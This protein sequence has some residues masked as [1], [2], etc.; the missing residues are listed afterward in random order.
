M[1]FADRVDAGRRLAPAVQKVA[2]GDVVVLGLPRGGV[3]VAA[4]VAKVLGAPLDV[5]VVRKLGVPRQPELAMGAVGEGG[6]CVLEPATIRAA[7]VSQEELAEIQQREREQVE[8]RTRMFRGDR[9]G[10]SLQGRT[11]IVVDDGIAT[12]ATM[13]AAC[14]IVRERGARRVVAAVPVAAG[15]AAAR[16]AGDADE[17]VCLQTPAP[18][19]G[20]GRWYR[21]FS[22]TS[23]AEVINLL[24]R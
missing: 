2:D 7:H 8:L 11:V 14:R 1:R 12:G 4:E 20:V 17:T 19:M 15:S 6:V 24:A 3:P 9:P 5:I 23:D 18:F 21:D 13:R 22:P 10:V 16:L